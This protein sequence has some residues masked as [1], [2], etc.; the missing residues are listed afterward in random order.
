MRVVASNVLV[1]CF[2]QSPL[3]VWFCVQPFRVHG[4]LECS[5]SPS[6][7]P[8][9]AMM[10]TVRLY[11][12]FSPHHLY[13]RTP[14]ELQVI[15]TGSE[16]SPAPCLLLSSRT[17]GYVHTAPPPPHTHT[18]HHHHHHYRRVAAGVPVATQPHRMHGTGHPPPHSLAPYPC[19]CPL[20]VHPNRHSQPLYL[21]NVPEGLSRFALEHRLLRPSRGRLAAIFWT[22]MEYDGVAG[23]GGT[24]MRG[25]SDGAAACDVWCLVFLTLSRAHSS[26]VLLLLL[27]LL[28]PLQIRVLAPT[29]PD[30]FA[31]YDYW[32]ETS[33]CVIQWHASRVSLLLP[34][35]AINHA[36]TLAAGGRPQR[37]SR[38]NPCLASFCAV[39][40]SLSTMDSAVLGLASLVAV[41]VWCPFLN[42]M[43]H[44]MMLLDPMMLAARQHTCD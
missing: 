35:V 18:H 23:F 39:R 11:Q 14:M 15:G 13:P 26:L 24:V 25:R 27:L 5:G 30:A 4:E 33:M 9:C 32:I 37:V 22:G 29:E 17:Q 41:A 43:L 3:T 19:S 40:C 1:P 28:T 34:V 8:L 2:A 6:S 44:S 31:S 36:V 12:L 7:F 38:A 16:G 42:R 20:P 21:F 10:S